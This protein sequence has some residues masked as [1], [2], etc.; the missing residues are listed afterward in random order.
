V[1]IRSRA[2]GAGL[3]IAVMYAVTALWSG[4]LSPLARRP[5]LDG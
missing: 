5:L 2:L 1:S 4:H 3:A